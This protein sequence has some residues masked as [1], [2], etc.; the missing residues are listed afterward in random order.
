MSTTELTRRRGAQTGMAPVSEDTALAIQKANEAAMAAFGSGSSG[1]I[2]AALQVA[3]SMENLRRLF[4]EPAIE[5]RITALQDTAIGFRTDRDPKQRNRK[6]NQPNEPYPYD[7]VKDCAI[8]AGLRGLQLVGNQWN[9]I[10]GRTYCTKEGFEF[11]IKGLKHVTDFKVNLGVP[12][13]K[14]GGVIIECEGSWNNDGKPQSLKSSI[15]V[16]SDDYSSADQLLGKATRKF[17]KRCYE[18][19]TGNTMPEGEAGEEGQIE[20]A[21]QRQQIPQ[22]APKFTAPDPAPAPAPAPAQAPAPA[23]QA[24]PTDASGTLPFPSPVQ[25]DPAPQA[26]SGAPPQTELDA[27]RQ[28][29]GDGF[30]DSGVSFDDFVQWIAVARKVTVK[31]DGFAELEEV[32][33]R[34]LMPNLPALIKQA[35][36]WV[37][38]GRPS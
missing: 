13:N 8:E 31:A 37:E 35:K 1:N 6:T 25:T 22:K 19:M 24:A 18:M 12:A 2:I 29:I 23:P 14:P 16:K 21:P 30:A 3:E 9:I 32:I 17:L 34:K 7:V 4:D 28:L 5:A 26:A 38:N 33:V 15:P 36:A 11:L 27:K 20:A 10:S